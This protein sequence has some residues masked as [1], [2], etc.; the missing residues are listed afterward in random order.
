[1]CTGTGNLQWA[2]TMRANGCSSPHVTFQVP[3]MVRTTVHEASYSLPPTYVNQT[4]AGLVMAIIASTTS[5]DRMAKLGGNSGKNAG[6][7]SVKDGGI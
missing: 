1:M 7:G 3:W 6:G 4:K 5:V 2:D